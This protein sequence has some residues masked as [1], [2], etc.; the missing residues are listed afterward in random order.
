MNIARPD[1]VVFA[2]NLSKAY[3]SYQPAKE[4]SVCARTQTQYL[5]TRLERFQARVNE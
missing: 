1:D 3:R 4:L 5:K 2:D